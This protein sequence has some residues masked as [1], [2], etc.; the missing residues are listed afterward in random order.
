[1]RERDFDWHLRA[2]VSGIPL[3]TWHDRERR[4]ALT[5]L[6]SECEVDVTVLSPFFLRIRDG[7]GSDATTASRG[8][9]ADASASRQNV[10]T[11]HV[12]NF[13][14]HVKAPYERSNLRYCFAL[15]RMNTQMELS[16]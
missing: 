11:S 15:S 9:D 14:T 16:F 1:M 7:R 4:H 5:T 13:D 12:T 8:Y 6:R 3:P 2:T 10:S